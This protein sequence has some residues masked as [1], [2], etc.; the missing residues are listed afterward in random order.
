MIEGIKE[1]NQKIVSLL[2]VDVKQF[3]QIVMIAQG[4]FTKLIY[5]SSD[6]REKVLRNL[7][8]TEKYRVLEEQLKEQSKVYQE[9]Y[10][11]LYQQR[12]LQV[13][14]LNIED[15]TLDMYQI[16]KEKEQVAK[17]IQD[18]SDSYQKEFQEKSQELQYIKANNARI[19][20]LETLTKELLQLEQQKEQYLHI[21]KDITLIKEIQSLLPIYERKEVLQSQIKEIHKEQKNKAIELKTITL[22]YQE[23]QK[24]NQEVLNKKTARN[25]LETKYQSM[26]QTKEIYVTW[27][28]EKQKLETITKELYG[29][30]E[31]I[32]Q[33][34]KQ[35]QEKEK[36]LEK[37]LQSISMIEV[38]KQEFII[39]QKEYETLHQRKT[40]IHALHSLYN[41][42]IQ[43]EEARYELA[44]KYQVIEK[45]QEL[46]RAIF[47]EMERQ[48]Q[49]FQAGM[50]ASSLKENTP[51][52]VCG[53]LH[54]PDPAHLHKETFD[55]QEYTYRKE[56]INVL[57]EKQNEAYQLVLLKKQ[58]LDLLQKDMQHKKEELGIVKD[59]SKEVFIMELSSI[60]RK[61][62]AMKIEYQNTK[63]EIEY[64]EKLKKTIEN[65]Q[66]DVNT[67][68]TQIET[69]YLEKQEIVTKRDQMDGKLSTY[70]INTDISLTQ[71]EESI[72]KGQRDI[73]N[74]TKEIETIEDR[75]MQISDVKA[76][77]ESTVQALLK[78]QIQLE[79]RV[80]LTTKE[81]E[82]M[83][84]EHGLQ[85]EDMM[86]GITMM[87]QLATYEQQYQTYNNQVHRV[88]SQQ[89]LLHKEVGTL[90]KKDSTALELAIVTLE[91]K[92]QEVEKQVVESKMMVLHYQQVI[93]D[94]EY[95]DV[96]I[97]RM[98]K[99]LQ[100]YL[101]LS[102]IT[103]GKNNYRVSLERYVL[104]AYFERV[105][106]YAN[107]VLMKMSQG[108]YQLYRRDNRS[109]GNGKQG[110]ELDVLDLESGLQRD[111]KT[112][113]GGESF[114]AALSLALGM[115]QMI[116]SHVGG[117][118]LQTLFI[119]EG[120]GTLDNQSLDQA[121]DC[122]LELQQDNKLIGIISH[123]S[124]LKERID[125]KIVV[126]RKHQESS[127]RLE[128][129]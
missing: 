120:F 5:A 103:S 50:L 109:K 15:E 49:Y 32:E 110:L 31:K 89:A 82:K 65:N 23:L 75:Y 108:R 54:H 11:T 99:Q 74:I 87:P 122:L 53:S 17:A 48:Y 61:E 26:L 28:K 16:V 102:N 57:Q 62:K 84:Q 51:C 67:W 1:V 30:N 69:T 90:E 40:E 37:D 115:S 29:I 3:K 27:N 86:H 116:Q 59:L 14:K 119:D 88:K 117:I 129:N 24:Q 114:K 9:Q 112:L 41:Q 36:K 60:Q 21:Q 101:H 81:Y 34:E 124:E 68:Q 123:V 56:E 43:E 64:L 111:V 38:L 66:R 55:Y 104:A 79:E 4:E 73:D 7:F 100:Q 125:N 105:L 52:P 121:I 96:Q 39:K 46:K 35:K 45:E 47:H 10:N 78:Q 42:S 25:Q 98:Q 20:S 85:E 2:G 6:E 18:T 13:Q 127:I 97:E 33:I 19:Q 22:Q 95:M 80:I 76:R 58:E 12:M 70:T 83:L 92:L 91:K 71:L 94:I 107:T 106:V 77:L 63:H 72:L 126:T 8:H 118:E 44:E 128:T 113:S 93:T